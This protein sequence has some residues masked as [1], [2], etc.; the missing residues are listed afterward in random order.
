MSRPLNTTLTQSIRRR[1]KT[2]AVEEASDS[3]CLDAQVE[4]QGN[5]RDKQGKKE[6]TREKHA[7]REKDIHTDDFF[8]SVSAASFVGS[9]LAVSR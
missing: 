5:G 6:K 4:V 1:L 9:S 7:S 3:F 8:S 2:A